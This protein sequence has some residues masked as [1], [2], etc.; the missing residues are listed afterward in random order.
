MATVQD[1][2]TCPQCGYEEAIY[3]LRTRIGEESIFCPMCGYRWWTQV[4]F[5]R[6]RQAEDPE[7]RLWLKRRKDGKLILR[8]YERRGYGAYGIKRK[9]GWVEL[10]HFPCPV[11][12]RMIEEFRQIISRDPEILADEC[13]MT[14]WN[15][16]RVE[17]VLGNVDLA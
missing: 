1:Y 12:D 15:E 17:V 7:H 9:D 2:T 3:E 5:D 16:D 6:K 11:T 13:W 14:R 8:C 10:G 4:L